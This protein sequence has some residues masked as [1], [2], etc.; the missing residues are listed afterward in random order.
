MKLALAYDIYGAPH[1][2]MT[3]MKEKLANS[4]NDSFAD[5]TMYME[6]SPVM[7]WN[8]VEKI[9]KEYHT[10]TYAHTHTSTYTPPPHPPTQKQNVHTLLGTLD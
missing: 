10:H 4:L 3:T 2:K 5:R 6:L 1:G 8:R 7:C 9:I